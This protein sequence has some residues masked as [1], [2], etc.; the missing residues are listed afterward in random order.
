MLS[1]ARSPAAPIPASP[2]SKPL[3]GASRISTTGVGDL[4]RGPP[5]VARVGRAEVL[6]DLGLGRRAPRHARP[7]ERRSWATWVGRLAPP[8]GAQ[9]RGLAAFML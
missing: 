9:S 7:G 6:R 5:G 2:Q 1:I 4:G 3:P 8:S